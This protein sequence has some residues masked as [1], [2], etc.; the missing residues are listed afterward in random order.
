V[1]GAHTKGIVFTQ[2]L[3]CGE[4]LVLLLFRAWLGNLGTTYSIWPLK[5]ECD[6][7]LTQ[8]A[9]WCSGTAR[10]LGLTPRGRLKF[11]RM[12]ACR[13]R[14]ARNRRVKDARRSVTGPLSAASARYLRICNSDYAL[15]YLVINH[16]PAA[17][18]FRLLKP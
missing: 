17:S 12:L 1:G 11:G 8:N 10:H 7:F 16:P 3:W 18:S 5:F 9:F 14:T 6:C 15:G 4:N 13:T 2:H